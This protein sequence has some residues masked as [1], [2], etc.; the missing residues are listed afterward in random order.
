MNVRLGMTL[1]AALVVLACSNSPTE[2]LLVVNGA[3]TAGPCAL[4]VGGNPS[5]NNPPGPTPGGGMKM[6]RRGP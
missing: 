5:T 2:P 3:C 6:G 1:L 4:S